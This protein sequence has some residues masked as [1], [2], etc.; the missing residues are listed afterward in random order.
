MTARESS[1]RARG[2]DGCRAGTAALA[3]MVREKR[4]M[5]RGCRLVLGVVEELG[6]MEGLDFVD[7]VSAVE[8]A[9]G[10]GV[11]VSDGW[12]GLG[13]DDTDRIADGVASRCCP[14]V[15]LEGS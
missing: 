15:L 8:R 2:G 10:R 7:R 13:F 1:E 4:H 9:D 3:T 11:R 12:T 6:D 14:A 5:R